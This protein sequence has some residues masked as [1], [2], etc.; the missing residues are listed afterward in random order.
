MRAKFEEAL[1]RQ[2]WRQI[3][4]SQPTQRVWVYAPNHLL[5]RCLD[6][7]NLPYEHLRLNVHE[8][9]VGE[10]ELGTHLVQAR[11][12]DVRGVRVFPTSCKR[13][14]EL[15]KK[16]SPGDLYIDLTTTTALRPSS[17]SK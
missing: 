15:A 13:V 4:D 7:D 6:L 5:G 12:Y 14:L 16:I 11:L 10:F 17:S 1:V 3:V 8:D 9:V 2:T